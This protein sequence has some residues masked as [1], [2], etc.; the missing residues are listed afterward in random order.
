MVMDAQ[1]N[2]MGFPIKRLAELCIRVT[3]VVGRIL[4]VDVKRLHLVHSSVSTVGHRELEAVVIVSR[5]VCIKFLQA[6][7]ASFQELLVKIDTAENEAFFYSLSRVMRV[8]V[9]ELGR[10]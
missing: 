7:S 8:Q 9:F 6:H 5:S 10:H 3:K 2:K 4:S 1:V